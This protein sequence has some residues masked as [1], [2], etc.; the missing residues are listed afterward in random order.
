MNPSQIYYTAKLHS[1]SP[2]PSFITFDSKMN[3]FTITDTGKLIVSYLY[4]IVVVGTT[5]TKLSAQFK[6]ML[7]ITNATQAKKG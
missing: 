5:N 3:T 4:S 2:V 6:F 1:G 7:Q